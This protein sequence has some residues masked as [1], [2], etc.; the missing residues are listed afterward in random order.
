MEV[1]TLIKLLDGSNQEYKT[2]NINSRS[3]HYL[4]HSPN[5]TLEACC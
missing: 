2:F 1:K 5:S 3:F 4:K